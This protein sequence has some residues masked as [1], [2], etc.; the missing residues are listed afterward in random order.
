ML[1]FLHFL[2]LR[3]QHFYLG[4]DSI[5]PDQYL[6]QTKFSEPFDQESTPSVSWYG[7]RCNEVKVGD[8]QCCWTSVVVSVL[9]NCQAVQWYEPCHKKTCLCLRPGKTQTS[10]L[11]YRSLLE[12]WNFC[13]SKHRYYTI[14]AANNK[15]LRGWAGWSAPLLFAYGKKRFSHYVARIQSDYHH[16]IQLCHNW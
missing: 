2:V 3:V 11:S 12:A 10:L 5:Q 1:L 16:T 13:Y 9:S 6:E 15:G 8:M 7:K 4:T 14:Q